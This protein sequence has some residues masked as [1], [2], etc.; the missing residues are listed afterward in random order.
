MRFESPICGIDRAVP[1]RVEPAAP[2]PCQRHLTCI[3]SFL[4]KGCPP[5]KLWQRWMRARMG[6]SLVRV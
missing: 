1:V 2:P 5:Y 4:T 3:P 6:G